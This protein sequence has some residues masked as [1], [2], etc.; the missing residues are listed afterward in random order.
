MPVEGVRRV[1]FPQLQWWRLLCMQ[2]AFRS[3]P[4]QV[5]S[6]TGTVMLGP[7]GW[8]AQYRGLLAPG[9]S[10]MQAIASGS[11]TQRM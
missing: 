11:L 3:S 7:E 4:V 6:D 2:G 8:I 1:S 9:L 10:K 5:G